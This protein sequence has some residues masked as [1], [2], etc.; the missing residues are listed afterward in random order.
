MAAGVTANARAA[1]ILETPVNRDP[2]EVSRMI[3]RYAVVG[4]PVSHSLSPKIHRLF[5][6]QAQQQITYEAIE[7]PIDN[8]AARIRELQGQGMKGLNV[9]VP[10]KRQAWEICDTRAARAETAGAVNTLVFKQDG[11]IMG[12]NSDGAG[13]VR[14]LTINHHSMIKHRKILILGAGGATRGILEPLL[15]LGPKSLT[16]VNRRLEKAEDLVRDFQSIGKFNSCGYDD[17]GPQKYDLI[18]NATAAGLNN[19]IPPVTDSVLGS[20][21]ICY[22]LMYKLKEPTVF[23]LWA[24]SQG[25]ARVFDGLG[26]LV[27]QAAESFFIW[28]GVRVETAAII[29]EL[30]Q[31]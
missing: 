31:I 16:I 19:E 4:N 17:L 3:D 25:A 13:L 30:R 29:A 24:Q 27:E 12:D 21:S 8:F 11:E 6:E 10:F 15:A 9:T 18:I 28:R 22:D 7:L 14:D 2:T 26:M 23:V 20:N 1:L 5:A